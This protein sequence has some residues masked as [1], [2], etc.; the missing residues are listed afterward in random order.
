MANTTITPATADT[1]PNGGPF[2]WGY[3]PTV[4]A[5]G[6]TYAPTST[7]TRVSSRT[8]IGAGGGALV[9]QLYTQ[10]MTVKELALNV[11]TGLGY[12]PI[13]ATVIGFIFRATDMDTGGSPA[14]VQSLFLNTT[15]VVTALAV[16]KTG[17]GGTI[18]PITPTAITAETVLYVKTTTAAQTVAA[19]TVYVTALYY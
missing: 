5:G 12:L 9:G 11:K 19:G 2:I 17:T 16:G 1:P 13:G 4:I 10:A 15:E 7:G 3:A 14:L 18:S 8:G 6:V